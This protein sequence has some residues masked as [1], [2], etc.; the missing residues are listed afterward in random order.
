MSLLLSSLTYREAPA[1]ALHTEEVEDVPSRGAV[2]VR[3]TSSSVP[4][5]AEARY[6]T[7]PILC[8]IT[9]TVKTSINDFKMA[10][11]EGILTSI[12]NPQ[13]VY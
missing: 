1:T 5:M 7:R 8:H 10:A 3:G 13:C 12:I 11:N 6:V 9:E 2:K 4:V